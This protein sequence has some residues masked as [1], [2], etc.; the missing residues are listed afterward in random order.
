[1]RTAISFAALAAALCFA[2]P[3]AAQSNTYRGTL[4]QCADGQ[5]LQ[6]RA[7]QRYTIAAAAEFDTV[8]KI[9]RPG[10][11]D[12]LA[13]DDDGGDG[14][15]SRLNF[16]PPETGTYIACVTAYGSSGSGPYTVTVQNAP[17]LPPPVTR[18]TSTET[19]TWQVY[20]GTLTT[21]DPTDDGAPFDDYQIQ[22]PNGQRAIISLESPAFDTVLKV[23][24]ASE[25]GAA[26]VASDDD[27]G[28]GLNAFLI[29]APEHGGTYIVRA[30]SY[31]TGRTGAYRLRVMTSP[32]PQ[33]PDGADSGGDSD[34]D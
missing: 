23:Y 33:Q 8:L 14:T 11:D 1:M 20:D 13:Q 27:S 32:A 31:G 15:N 34:G 29:F 19:G 9:L 6:L 2:A 12:V 22:I 30:T 5:R 21:A 7:G 24:S 16:T 17:P 3:A 28:G 4:T 10:S 26:A 25:R 18:P